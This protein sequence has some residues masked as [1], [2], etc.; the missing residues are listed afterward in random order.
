MTKS[1]PRLHIVHLYPSELGINGDV[2]N[3]T[4]LAFRG[5]AYGLDV[6][7]TNVGRGDALPD[8]V[9]LVHIGSGPTDELRL[10]L[11]DIT[12][13][14][15]NLV[16]LRDSGVPFVA[17]SAGW[18]ALSQVVTFADGQQER[19]A[20]V[21]PTSVQ[22]LSSRVVGEI[23]LDTQWGIVTG[24]ENHSAQVGDAGL[25]HLGVVRAGAGSDPS[26]S[27]GQRWEG[28]V[29]GSSIGTNVHGSLLPMN[30]DIADW[31]I[32][33]AVQRTE[34]GWEIP[35]PNARPDALTD[36]DRFAA[37]SRDAVLKRL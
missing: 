19:G 9:D 23:A 5:V 8:D 20:S 4:T 35:G 27:R 29:M 1:V 32:S 37:Q 34:P 14:A 33:A 25:P 28:V 7:V 10:V 13:L 15:G 31:L 24:F 26:A 22:L 21:F 6:H 16:K 17:I 11:D 30:P 18:F 36:V 3:V 2:G 12:R